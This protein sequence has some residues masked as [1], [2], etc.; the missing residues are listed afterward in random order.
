MTSLLILTLFPA[1]M[2]FASLFDLFTMKIPNAIVL[3]LLAGFCIAAPLSG[4]GI[5]TA[6][7]SVGIASAVLVVGFVLFSLNIMGG[8][9][10]KILF[11]SSL[12]LGPAGTLDY[13]LIV[14]LAGGALTLLLMSFR[15]MP[16]PEMAMQVSWIDR[17]H[18]RET[19][20]PY[21]VALG[22]AALYVFPA[23][24][25]ALFALTGASVG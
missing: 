4:M 3:A 6:L 17:L 18:D 16:L 22:P 9:D 13:L 20:V 15:R 25:L 14:G 1:A 21:G 11:A 23:T 12:W 5:E 7:W 19:G 10:A 24:P 2:L 8:G